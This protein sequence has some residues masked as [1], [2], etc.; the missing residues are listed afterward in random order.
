MLSGPSLIHDDGVFHFYTQFFSQ[1]FKVKVK[2]N[3]VL[4]YGQAG[5]VFIFFPSLHT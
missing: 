4:F 5:A 3:K 1:L 2:A